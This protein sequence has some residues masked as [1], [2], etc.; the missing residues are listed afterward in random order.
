MV[1]GAPLDM[2]AANVAIDKGLGVPLARQLADWVRD[3]IRSGAL[4]DRDGA[5]KPLPLPSRDQL[6]RA[7]GVSTT[8]AREAMSILEGEGLVY[9]APGRGVFVHQPTVQRVVSSHRYRDHRIAGFVERQGITAAE[10]TMD[11]CRFTPMPAPP[12]VATALE[13]QPGEPVLQ[14]FQVL[15]ARGLA[16]E[17]RTSNFP[18]WLVGGHP[19]FLDPSRQPVPGGLMTELVDEVGVVFRG[20]DGLVERIRTRPPTPE[21]AQLLR[22]PAGWGVLVSD[23]RISYD[24][25]DRPVEMAQIVYPGDRTVLEIH[26][27]MGDVS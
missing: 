25:Q 26:I 12:E 9:S 2:Y 22:I 6:M 10:Y 13:I 8:T 5:G 3:Q 14:R 7:H 16:E 11:P 21:E 23:P 20:Q 15:R 27:D 24:A 1:V 4:P 19:E 18:M 17:I